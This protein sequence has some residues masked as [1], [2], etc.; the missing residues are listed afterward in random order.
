[1]PPRPFSIP[2][3]NAWRPSGF[4]GWLPRSAISNRFCRVEMAHLMWILGRYEAG[5]YDGPTRSPMRRNVR[6]NRP[7]IRDSTYVSHSMHVF[8]FSM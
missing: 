5:S 8:P 6:S 3:S 1:M 2:V 7:E 4:I